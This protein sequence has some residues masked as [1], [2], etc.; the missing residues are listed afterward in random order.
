MRNEVKTRRAIL[1][2]TDIPPQSVSSEDGT[3]EVETTTIG[4]A[5]FLR[6]VGLPN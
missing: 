2:G 4:N 6:V 3:Q 5:Q 1:A